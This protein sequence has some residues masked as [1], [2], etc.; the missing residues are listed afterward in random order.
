MNSSLHN[1]FIQFILKAIFLTFF[2]NWNIKNSE[3]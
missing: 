1:E 3:V 2:K